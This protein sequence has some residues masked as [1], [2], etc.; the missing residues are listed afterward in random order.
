MVQNKEIKKCITREG[1]SFDEQVDVDIMAI[2]KRDIKSFFQGLLF[3]DALPANFTLG[4]YSVTS[5]F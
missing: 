4:S 2:M 3:V 1:L 5:F